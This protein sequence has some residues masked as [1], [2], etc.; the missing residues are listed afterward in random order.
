MLAQRR[1]KPPVDPLPLPS[2]S[3]DTFGWDT[4]ENELQ[5]DEGYRI[6]RYQDT[7][8]H[9]TIG[10]GHNLDASPLPAGWTEP[11]SDAQVK[12]LLKLD[13]QES[14]NEL[15]THIPWWRN[16]TSARQRVLINMCFN[17][18]WG[19]LSTFTTFLRLVEEGHYVE[20]SSDMLTTLWAKQVKSRATRLAM[21]MRAGV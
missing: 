6:K 2:N 15:D 7:Q 13:M 12:Q 14:I 5:L 11:L 20:A 4:L 17:L 16:L 18:G 21:T 19:S 9:W 3:K 10:V 8:G 1:S